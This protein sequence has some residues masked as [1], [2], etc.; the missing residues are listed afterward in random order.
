MLAALEQLKQRAPRLPLPPEA[1]RAAVTPG[2]LGVVNNAL[3]RNHYL[4]PELRSSPA[5]R[6]PDPAMQ[7]D[8]EFSVELFWIVSRVN[9]CHYCLGHQEVKLKAGGMAEEKLL[10]L[11]TN[12]KQFPPEQQAAFQFARKLTFAPHAIT[13][14]DLETLREHFEPLRMLEIVFLVARYNSTNRWTDS[15]GLPQEDHRDYASELK[16]AGLQQKSQ[17]V[18]A[19][20]PERPEFLDYA[21]WRQAFDQA[22]TRVARLPLADHVPATGAAA[23]GV[24]V[25][26]AAVGSGAPVSAAAPQLARLLAVFPQAGTQWFQQFEA[27]QTA[28]SLAPEMKA[29]IAY[30]AARADQ[31]W[32]MQHHARARLLAQGLDE[33]SIFEL[34]ARARAAQAEAAQERS[35]EAETLAFTWKLTATPNQMTD[36][37]IERLLKHYQPAEVAE[38]V[39]HVGLAAFLDRLTESAGLGWVE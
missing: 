32:Y 30:V 35:A 8:Q 14:S 4:P 38:V 33:A 16:P 26:A 25:H 3:M 12:W 27:A 9:N 5:A 15:L 18:M 34:A 29:R 17:V 28:G 31:A 36:T 21:Q 23:A 6:T 7:L 22:S 20:F 13:D 2:A 39:Y 19:S 11:D 37:D 10:A 1:A 24:D